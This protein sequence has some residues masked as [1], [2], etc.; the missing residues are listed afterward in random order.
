[1]EI[2]IYPDKFSDNITVE[3]KAD[4]EDHCIIVLA[5]QMGRI[6]RMMGVNVYQGENQFHVD[7]LSSLDSG[8]YEINVKNKNSKL[9]Y[10]SMLT[11][12]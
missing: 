1:M 11:K 7:N 9:L 6:L 12:F 10:S 3:I 2:S 4:A 8:V 5:N